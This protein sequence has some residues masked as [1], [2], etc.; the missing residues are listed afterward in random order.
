MMAQSMSNTQERK[1]MFEDPKWKPIYIK[2]QRTNKNKEKEQMKQITQTELVELIKAKQ[3]NA[4]NCIESL[5]RK[6][7][8]SIQDGLEKTL[9]FE[10]NKA[11]I[12]A[13]QDLICYLN[14]KIIVPDGAIIPEIK[15][16]DLKK[17]LEKTPITPYDEQKTCYNCAD[18]QKCKEQNIACN[19]S[20]GKPA[21]ND[22]F[23][24]FINEE[25]GKTI[26]EKEMVDAKSIQFIRFCKSEENCV[27]EIWGGCGY[28][29]NK[30][31]IELPQAIAYYNELLEWW[32]YWKQM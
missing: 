15:K 1:N 9:S 14:G 20:G 17:M 21:R 5:G 32:K 6:D 13:Y 23:R 2:R 27:V 11:Y 16:E 10:R 26:D 19:G 4:K 31:F 29:T 18:Y 24:E 12:D 25:T 30:R 28:I 8:W 3:E 22:R 7:S